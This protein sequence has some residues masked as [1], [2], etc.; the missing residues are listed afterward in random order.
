MQINGVLR[1]AFP[2]P[3]TPLSIAWAVEELGNAVSSPPSSILSQLAS[4]AIFQCFKW[5]STLPLDLTVALTSVAPY[6][7]TTSFFVQELHGWC[8]NSTG[9]SICSFAPAAVQAARGTCDVLLVDPQIVTT[10]F[11]FLLPFLIIFQPWSHGFKKPNTRGTK[12][13]IGLWFKRSLTGL[14]DSVLDAAASPCLPPV[15][16]ES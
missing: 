1:F 7:T 14:L 12:N 8:H 16:G 15:K 13:P 2:P 3:P 5:L 4:G 11:F 6:L 10:G 9:E